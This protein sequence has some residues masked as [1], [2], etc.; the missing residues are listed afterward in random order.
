MLLHS[1]KMSIVY[2]LLFA[3]GPEKLSYSHFFQ[4]FPC[5]PPPASLHCDELGMLDADTEGK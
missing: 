2:L 5:A 4:M 1:A 3:F